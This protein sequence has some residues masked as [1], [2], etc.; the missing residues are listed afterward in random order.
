MAL[1]M[2]H[3]LHA[4]DCAGSP[5]A[6]TSYL[7]VSGD[8]A[9]IPPQNLFRNGANGHHCLHISLGLLLIQHAIK[10]AS[11]ARCWLVHCVI[12]DDLPHGSLLH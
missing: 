9:H 6:A 12:Y 4:D 1:L 5:A 7:L 10:T 3:E 2:P 11:D 8:Q